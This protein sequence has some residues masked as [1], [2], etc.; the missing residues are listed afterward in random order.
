MEAPR[1]VGVVLAAGRSTRAGGPKA[2]ARYGQATFLERAVATL[3]EGGCAQVTVVL[4]AHGPAIRARGVDA[5]LVE[6][7]DLEAGMLHSLQLGLEPLPAGGAQ[8]VAVCL[9]DHPAVQATTV[10]E[11]AG[12]LWA[13]GAEVAFPTY[14]GLR[15]HPFVLAPAAV[16]AVLAAAPPATVRTALAGLAA[17]TVEVDDP[18]VLQDLDLRED[19]ER[20]AGG[21]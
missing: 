6:N 8:G 20:V 4:G 1:L 19:V 12:R 9:V 16:A 21:G 7:T 5:Q 13:T 3:R 15:G 17:C 14:R 11:L 18:G 2:L 10:R